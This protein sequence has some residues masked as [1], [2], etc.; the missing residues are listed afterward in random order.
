MRNTQ[1]AVEA[2]AEANNDRTMSQRAKTL[3]MTK[4]YS[5]SFATTQTIPTER[6][7]RCEADRPSG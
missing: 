6:A 5:A 1:E 3:E 2:R 7:I 4:P